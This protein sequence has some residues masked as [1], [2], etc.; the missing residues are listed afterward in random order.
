MN[1]KQQRK[2]F[3]RWSPPTGY[4]ENRFMGNSDAL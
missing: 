4:R 1:E 3:L 2:M